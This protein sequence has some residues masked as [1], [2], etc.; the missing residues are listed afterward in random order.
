VFRVRALVLVGLLL[1]ATSCKAAVEVSIAVADDGSGVVAVTATFDDEARVRLGGDLATA[2]HTDDLKAT[3]WSVSA[4]RHVGD[5]WQITVTKPFG[6]PAGLQAVL[7]EVG[8]KQGVFRDWT[9][10]IDRSFG[11]ENWT[12][13]GRVVLSG[14]L[15]QFG[16]SDLTK[17]LGGMPL[18]R[19]P[20]QLQEELGKGGTI[21]LTV[22][23]TLPASVDSAD[24]TNGAAASF[25]AASVHWRYA[26]PGKAI[27]EQLHTS[28]AS[29]DATV[30]LWLGLAAVAFVAAV[31]LWIFTRSRARL[32]G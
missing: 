3:G 9:I 24:D 14:S 20:Q 28:A 17:S 23:V 32:R 25:P 13:H 29:A 1:A 10:K 4:P 18:G 26:L 11:L 19:T 22:R 8:G 27:D 31:S 21:P 2:L 30:Y 7:D 16:D 6:S 15:D 12:V 5:V